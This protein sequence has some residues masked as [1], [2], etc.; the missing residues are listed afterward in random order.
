MTEYRS[1]QVLQVRPRYAALD[2]ALQV[3]IEVPGW[4]QLLGV[5]W[6][7]EQ[8]HSTR[9]LQ[10][11]VGLFT[12]GDAGRSRGGP[13]KSRPR[14]RRDAARSRAGLQSKGPV[15]LKERRLNVSIGRRG[16]PGQPATDRCDVHP[17]PATEGPG[18]RPTAACE[19]CGDSPYG[20]ARVSSGSS[21]AGPR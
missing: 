10:R 17:V 5:W 3:T 13:R 7:I 2:L 16:S 11:Y 1:L 9:R 8:R 15:R 4:I 19:I 12:R 14:D 20:S 21:P 6:Q 18:R